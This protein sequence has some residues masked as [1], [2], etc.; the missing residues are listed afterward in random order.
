MEEFLLSYTL[1]EVYLPA[2]LVFSHANRLA[3]QGVNFY[4]HLRID[5]NLQLFLSVVPPLAYV[6]IFMSTHLS[7]P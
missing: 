4:W 3:H 2:G 7:V 6:F 5:S 1:V